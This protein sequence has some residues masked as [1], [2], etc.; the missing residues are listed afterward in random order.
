MKVK[1]RNFQSIEDQTI[2]IEGLTVVT[3]PSNRGKSALIRA[4]SAV[5]LGRP[6]DD[7]VRH[8]KKETGVRVEGEGFQIIWRRAIKPTPK[9]PSI[10]KVNGA[11][12][13]RFGRDHDALTKEVGV[14]YVETTRG[15]TTPQ[16]ARQHDSPF[17]VMD[18]E[19]EAA[20]LLKMMARADQVG[21]AQEK[22]GK[23]RRTATSLQKVR[24]QDYKDAVEDFVALDWT[25]EVRESLEATKEFVFMREQAV[26]GLKRQ[27]DKINELGILEPLEVPD[28]PILDIVPLF[29]LS[30]VKEALSL[31]PKKLSLLPEFPPPSFKALALTVVAVDAIKALKSMGL[32][33]DREYWELEELGKRKKELEE[34]LK[35]CPA[36]GRTFE[37]VLV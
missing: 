24:E 11:L 33:R 32:A 23:D 28:I 7:H 4:L 13:T 10:L 8:G 26:V 14:C 27:I 9:R 37:S 17:L 1:V 22:A 35:K 25:V 2:E 18:S 31:T 20:E 36:C 34:E 6:G 29:N 30:L 5:F 12:H 16:I 21:R 15:K 19:A 3:G